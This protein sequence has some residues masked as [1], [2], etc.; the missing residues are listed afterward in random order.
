M[1]LS[2]SSSSRVHL[3]ESWKSRLLSEFQQPYMQNLRKFLVQ[4]I[5]AKKKIYPS[6]SLYFHALNLVP[7]EKVKVVILG[8][9]P[10][11]GPGQA[12]GLC[13]SVLKGCPIPPSL[14]NIYKELKS[15]L[16]IPPAPHGH[17][18]SWAEQGV[19]LL[20]TVLTVESGKAGSHKGQGWEEFTNRIIQL[21]NEERQGLVFLLWGRFASEKAAFVD[22]SRHCV[23][24]A[25][26]PSP[27]SADRGFFACRHFSKSN[28]FLKSRGTKPINWASHLTPA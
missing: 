4:E 11:H 16:G 21:L 9:D 28:E 25:P 19:F 2:S 22:P 6:P 23:L 24:K 8:Q 27:F 26:H 5:Q 7:F 10:Y 20:N 15:D 3:S 12:H 13:F 18:K 17:L 14:V 1:S